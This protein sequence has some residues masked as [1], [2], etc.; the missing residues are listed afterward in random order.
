M[1]IFGC[2][3]AF[4]AAIAPRL[5]L[6]FAWIFAPRWDLAFRNGIILPILGIVFAPYTA[7]MYLLVWSPTGLVGFDWVWI[8]L[9][10]LLDIM[11]WGQI[12]RHR[13]GIPGVNS[14]RSVTAV[15]RSITEPTA[16]D[17]RK[18]AELEELDRQRD[19][20]EITEGEYQ[21]RK[22]EINK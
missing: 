10:V 3:L 12:A 9:G 19:A 8:G 18:W 6:I 20:G 4:G 21:A 15:D 13:E 5:V 11:K 14:S 16:E 7:I 1:L 2:L 17:R 22:R